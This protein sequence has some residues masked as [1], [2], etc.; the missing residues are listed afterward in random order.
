MKSAAVL[1]LVSAASELNLEPTNLMSI[2]SGMCFNWKGEDFY[3]LTSFDESNRDKDA[4][5]ASVLSTTGA[6]FE[7]KLCQMPW[8]MT[9]ANYGLAAATPAW[10]ATAWDNEFATAFWVDKTSGEATYR[11]LNADIVSRGADENA[12]TGKDGWDI[13][14]TSLETCESDDLKKFTVELNGKCTG[15]AAGTWG[16]LTVDGCAA[17]VEYSG[18]EACVTKKI[19]IMKYLN[20]VAPFVGAILS[21]AGLVMCFYGCKFLFWVLG[22]LIGAVTAGGLFQVLYSL[23]MSGNDTLSMGVFVGVLVG[24]VIVGG[25]VAW[26]TS[27]L[28][29]KFGTTIIAGIGGA[30]L[31]LILLGAFG[32]DS[33]YAQ[34]GGAIAG[35]CLGIFIGWKTKKWVNRCGTAMIG[36][37]M[38]VRG[39][40]NYAGGWANEN[41]LANQVSNGNLHAVKTSMWL[42]FAGF[43]TLTIVGSF[44]QIS[45]VEEEKTVDED[46]AFANEDE[47]KQWC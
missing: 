20:K 37:F 11:F 33:V 47:M 41:A 32:V 43:V 10:D 6:T 15:E 16:A 8:E 42:Y 46:D 5:A 18:A 9:E 40:S 19:P 23:W 29:R 4:H 17:T 45:Y 12:D 25:L 7:Y 13:T 35:A 3:D 22:G 44:V 2:G 24:C 14:W 1:G 34:A 36:A 21:V 26:M 30:A 31:I 39:I 28:T 27:A 38:I